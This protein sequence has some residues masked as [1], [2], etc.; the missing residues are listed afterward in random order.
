MIRV[1][2]YISKYDWVVDCYFAVDCYYANEIVTKCHKLGASDSTLADVWA[3]LSSGELNGG[4]TYSN[5]RTRESVL[6][7]QLTSSA[8]EFFDSFVHETGHLATHIA[9]ADGINLEGEEV[10]YIQGDVAR[11]LFPSCRKLMCECCRKRYTD[12]TPLYKR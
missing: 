12:F 5:Y 4:I 10:R 3:K 2:L 1:T 6:V 9:I 7:T 11:A 8:D